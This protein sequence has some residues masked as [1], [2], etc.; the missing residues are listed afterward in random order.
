MLPGGALVGLAMVAATDADAALFNETFTWTGTTTQ[1][2][3]LRA[4][5]W[6]GGNAG[7]AV[8]NNSPGTIANQGGEGAISVGAGPNGNQGFAFWSQR[9]IGADGFLFTENVGFDG[10][11]V[12]QVTWQQRDSGSDP[13]HLV[14]RVGTDWYISDQS[15][16]ARGSEWQPQMA[17]IA[18][19]SFF[20]RA[21]DGTTL[22]GGGTP[23]AP[24]GLTLPTQLVNAF[25]FWWDGPK[26]G[27]SRIDD[28]NVVPIPGA[29]VLM[30]SGIAALGGMRYRRQRQ[31]QATA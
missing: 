22:P 5:G 6:C 26:T 18:T 1:D 13:T 3:E 20:M 16:T 27:T 9:R 14:F 12:T 31:A 10:G 7:D 30:L 24:G 25:G 29:V 23:S 28:I 15:F 2:L 8:C 17:D 11:D 19:M 4:Q 21:S